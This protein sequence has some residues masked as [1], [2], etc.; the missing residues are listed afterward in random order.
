MIAHQ[1]GTPVTLMLIRCDCLSE[2]P[3]VGYFDMKEQALPL[4]GMRHAV[5]VVTFD[6]PVCC[7]IRTAETYIAALRTFHR[8]RMP[9]GVLQNSNPTTEDTEAQYGVDGVSS[10]VSVRS[11]V[12]FEKVVKSMTGSQSLAEDW[13]SDFGIQEDGAI[14]DPTA[15]LH[16]SVVLRG[17]T[18]GR[19][20]VLVRSVA[21]PGAVV[22]PG[23]VVVDKLV[24]ADGVQNSR[25]AA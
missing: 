16:N 20:A 23:S 17:A 7:G 5:K 18:V 8:A 6:A 11:V 21:C 1:D 9:H 4:I 25:E 24:S 3:A 12:G 15:K 10:V 22:A 14:V 2:L 19:H 13:K